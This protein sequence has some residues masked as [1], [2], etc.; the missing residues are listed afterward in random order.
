MTR[1]LV[2]VVVLTAA[3]LVTVPS[4]PADAATSM[5]TVAMHVPPYCC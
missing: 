5:K 1:R 2:A 3:A 4:L